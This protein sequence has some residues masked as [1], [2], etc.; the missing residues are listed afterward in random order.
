MKKNHFF[1]GTFNI[2][3]ERTTQIYY[4]IFKIKALFNSTNCSEVISTF[5]PLFCHC[6]E[7]TVYLSNYKHLQKDNVE[8]GKGISYLSA[9]TT[10]S[11]RQR[12]WY[13]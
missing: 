10:P 6:P 12:T 4:W 1:Q 11:P 2:Y 8:R 9:A 7:D 3:Y 13:Y 5:I